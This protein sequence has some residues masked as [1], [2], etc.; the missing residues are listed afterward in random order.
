[1]SVTHGHEMF[2]LVSVKSLET[3]DRFMHFRK[4]LLRVLTTFSSKARRICPILRDL[5]KNFQEN[6]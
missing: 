1:M 3:L 5:A 4:P 2:G 6:E